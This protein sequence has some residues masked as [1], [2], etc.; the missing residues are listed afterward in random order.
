MKL[1]KKLQ[2]LISCTAGFFIG[3]IP[4]DLQYS[5]EPV[6]L[7]FPCKHPVFVCTSHT[8]MPTE[9]QFNNSKPH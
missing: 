2:I 1:Q 7:G 9:T 5:V 8:E 3:S 6:M 4:N